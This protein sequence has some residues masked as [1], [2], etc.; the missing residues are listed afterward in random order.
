MTAPS[1]Y[2]QR[3]LLYEKTSQQIL[4]LPAS[5]RLDMSPEGLPI[6]L[7]CWPGL[8][9]GFSADVMLV[10]LLPVWHSHVSMCKDEK[11]SCQHPLQR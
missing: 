1:C 10:Q 7:K 2:G 6:M 11:G 8:A 3:K 4:G 5:S 9:C